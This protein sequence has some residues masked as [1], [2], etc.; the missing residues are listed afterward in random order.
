[1]P[2]NC[3]PWPGKRR[4]SE[5]ALTDRQA[6]AARLTLAYQRSSTEPQTRPA[7]NAVSSTRSPD[8]MGRSRTHSSSAIGIEAADVFPK[9]SMFL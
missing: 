7:P 4:A 6:G 8:L 2:T 1:M 9:R 5:H 3:E